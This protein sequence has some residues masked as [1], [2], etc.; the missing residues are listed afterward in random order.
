MGN[1]SYH[2]IGSLHYIITFRA[3]LYP[4]RQVLPPP[5]DCKLAKLV[6]HP[7]R[8]APFKVPFTLTPTAP[9][10]AVN[11]ELILVGFRISYRR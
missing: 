1:L 10:E 9:T 6:L 2:L 11:Y 3:I 5:F 8:I 7:R 4:H